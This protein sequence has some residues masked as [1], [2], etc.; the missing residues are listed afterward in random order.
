MIFQILAITALTLF[1]GCYLHKMLMQRKA[2]IQTD[3]MGKGKTGFTKTIEIFM[4]IITYLVVVVEVVSIVL[5][6]SVFPTWLRIIGLVLTIAGTAFFMTAVYTMKDSW[7]AGVPSADKT[8]LVTA[9]VFQ[10]SRNPAFLGFDLVYI[11][12]MCLF[13]NVPLWV[14]SVAACLMLHLQI[15]NN[16]E[17]F[18]QEAFG[19]EYLAYE[20]RVN[21]YLGRR[22]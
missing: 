14:V 1:Y 13:F 5:N 8:S 21:R 7:R 3:Q 9:G 11:G 15:V 2:G 19:A 18:L 20:R 17:P 6:T 12:I 10:I 4:K 22:R 16:E